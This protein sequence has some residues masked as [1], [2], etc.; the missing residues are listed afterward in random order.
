MCWLVSQPHKVLK[1]TTLAHRLSD[2]VNISSVP[3]PHRERNSDMAVLNLI[4]SPWAPAL[5]VA[6]LAFYYLYPYFVTYKHL[7]NIPAPFPA[8]FSDLWLLSIVRRGKR[9]ATVDEIH[10]KLGPVVRIQPNHV[11]I[12][13]DEAIQ[14]IYG[15]GNGFLKS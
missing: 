11:S 12:N 13:D 14:V 3:L 9:Y 5:V 10:K 6:G 7:R 4:S 2:T 15:H 1:P 8:Q